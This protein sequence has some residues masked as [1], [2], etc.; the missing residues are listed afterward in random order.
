MR[1][2][3]EDTD[4]EGGPG[5]CSP[6]KSLETLKCPRLHFARFYGGEKEKDN[7]E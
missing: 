3:N 2:E 5:A 7:V 1:I 6:G 4:L